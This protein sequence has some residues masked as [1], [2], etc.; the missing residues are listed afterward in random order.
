MLSLLL[1][2]LVAFIIFGCIALPIRWAVNKWMPECR[3]KNILLKHRG[4]TK[5]SLSR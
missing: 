3:L 1:K 5:D 2:P 4:G